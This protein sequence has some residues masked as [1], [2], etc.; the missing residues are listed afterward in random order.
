MLLREHSLERLTINHVG[1]KQRRDDL[2]SENLLEPTRRKLVSSLLPLERSLLRFLM[3]VVSSVTEKLVVNLPQS[4][5]PR[6]VLL[7]RL[8]GELV[9][10]G[11]EN[12]SMHMLPD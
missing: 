7:Q 6:R 11:D 12:M 2:V 5:H 3:W 9:V 1:L 8:A 10:I 4:M